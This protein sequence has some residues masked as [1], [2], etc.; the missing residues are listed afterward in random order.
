MSKLQTTKHKV[1][2]QV[3]ERQ[4]KFLENRSK[5]LGLSSKA[6]LI[7]YYIV[8][9]MAKATVDE[10]KQDNFDK[11]RISLEGIISDGRVTEED[12]EEVEKEWEIPELR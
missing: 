9:D 10:H 11:K 3:V 2:I 5:E 1:T 12:I 7:K 4:I 8:S 6:D